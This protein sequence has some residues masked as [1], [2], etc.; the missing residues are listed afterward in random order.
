M[1]FIVMKR[2]GCIV[3]I[4]AQSIPS[5]STAILR[6]VVRKSARNNP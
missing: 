5:I 2:D 6:K 1:I 4:I 3:I